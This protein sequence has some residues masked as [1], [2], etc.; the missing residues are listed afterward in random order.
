MDVTLKLNPIKIIAALN[1]YFSEKFIP[2]SKLLLIVYKLFI[3]AP[4]IIAIEIGPIVIGKYSEI[5]L[6]IN[7][8]KTTN[9]KPCSLFFILFEIYNKFDY[10]FFPHSIFAGTATSKRLG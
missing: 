10:F 2:G 9:N 7:P 5:I 6:D 4:V 8:I 1:K 3:N